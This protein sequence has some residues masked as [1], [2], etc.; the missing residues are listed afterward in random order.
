[1]KN[2]DPNLWGLY[3]MLGNVSELCHDYY[4]HE[5]GTGAATDPWGPLT[6]TA[7]VKRGGSWGYHAW[8]AR[9]AYRSGSGLGTYGQ[10]LGFRL[11]RSLH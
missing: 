1:M 5:L 7:R 11:A 4:L 10:A 8:Y 9:A 6:G 2:K 3:D